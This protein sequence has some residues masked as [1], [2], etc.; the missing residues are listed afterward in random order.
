MWIDQMRNWI[1]IQKVSAV[2]N[3]R[4]P[5]DLGRAYA[6]SQMETQLQLITSIY[7]AYLVERSKSN[8]K[9]RNI[10]TGRYERPSGRK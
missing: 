10:H 5:F 8:D 7:G 4:D 6:F 3:V 2:Q 9:M 1:E